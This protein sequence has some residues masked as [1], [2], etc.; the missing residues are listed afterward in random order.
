MEFQF[1][2]GG[3][4][5]SKPLLYLWEIATPSGEVEYRYVGK[6]KN[7]ASRPKKH[8]KRNVANLI[9]GK[10]Y[11]KGKPTKFR[12]V[13]LRLRD[14][15]AQSLPITLVLLCNVDPSDDIYLR[16]RQAQALFCSKPY[17]LLHK[18]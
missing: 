3:V 12:E 9:A 17:C 13:H 4:D 6:S 8:Y 7:G 11:R 2:P 15:V 1:F 18:A 14:A 16:E 5:E 10:P